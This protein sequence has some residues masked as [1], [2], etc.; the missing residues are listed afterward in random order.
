MCD[1]GQKGGVFRF[2][3]AENTADCTVLTDS[4][5]SDEQE[6]CVRIHGMAFLSDKSIII[7]DSSSQ[8]VKML[9]PDAWHH[10]S[11]C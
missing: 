9:H 3:D 11:Y 4:E 5:N 1:I 8:N 2:N 10:G 6:A 7:I